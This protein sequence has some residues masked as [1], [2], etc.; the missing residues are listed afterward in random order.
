M[1]LAN[2]A[3]S[4]AYA[5]SPRGAPSQLCSSKAVAAPQ[6]PLVQDS[7]SGDHA[8]HRRLAVGTRQ[9]GARIGAGECGA[10]SL[11]QLFAG[12]LKCMSGMQR[13]DAMQRIR[14]REA[15]LL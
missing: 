1:R 8:P 12:M 6:R 2:E 5:R 9:S 4:L 15:L 11:H 14:L 10:D 3:I 13:T 7:N